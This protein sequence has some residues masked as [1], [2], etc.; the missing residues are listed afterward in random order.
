MIMKKDFWHWRIQ[1][2]QLR[3]LLKK[4]VVQMGLFDEKAC[5][6]DHGTLRLVLRRNP[7]VARKEAL[8]REDK[9]KKLSRLLEERNEFVEN[10]LRA[11]PETGLN[12]FARW[13][14]HHKLTSFVEIRLEARRIVMEIDADGKEQ[15]AL[16]DGCYVLETDVTADKMDAVTV[17][18]RYRDLQ[19]VER[20][21][22]NMKTALLEIRPIFVRK[23]SRT[24]GHV[25]SA[26][27][28]LKISREMEN[29]LKA[30][31]GT[32]E[33]SKDALTI[34][35]ALNALARLCFERYEIGGR[36]FLRLPRP[37]A[38]QLAI[39]EAVGVTPPRSTN[40]KPA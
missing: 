29:G 13:T 25:F 36:E 11:K 30:A 6:V 38:K 18:E 19:K 5:E 27:L 32:T 15:D 28:A 35:D 39:F 12:K 37:D 26:V 40:R 22:R 21:F 16:L 7:A 34:K 9:I 31:F 1:K 14:R 24:I 10:S 33:Q 2:I 23:K 3:K 20:D 4:D 17:D 8:R